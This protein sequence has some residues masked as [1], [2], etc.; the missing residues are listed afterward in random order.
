MSSPKKGDDF[1]CFACKRTRI[2]V[3]TA[4]TWAYATLQCQQCPFNYP[5]D[6]RHGKKYLV[7]MALR[8]ASSRNHK[9]HLVHDGTVDVIR[10]SGSDQLP[11]ID[12]LLL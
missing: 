1:F 3:G 9:V 10:G 8:H 7:A 12:D 2:V 6:G 11:L 5:N 4:T